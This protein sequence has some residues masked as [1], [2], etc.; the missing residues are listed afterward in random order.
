[1]ALASG[2]DTSI[3][4]QQSTLKNKMAA[5]FMLVSSLWASFRFLV[6]LVSWKILVSTAL[7]CILSKGSP[8]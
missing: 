2:I 7:L 6:M 3:Q 5:I 8:S 4:W 1:M